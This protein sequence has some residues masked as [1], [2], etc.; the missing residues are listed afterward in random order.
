MKFRKG[1]KK[2]LDWIFRAA[3]EQCRSLYEPGTADQYS[4][5]IEAAK[6]ELYLLLQQ[7]PRPG[8]R[9]K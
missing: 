3:Q 2:D 5:Q 4:E 8:N 1:L 9:I 7:A 6:Q